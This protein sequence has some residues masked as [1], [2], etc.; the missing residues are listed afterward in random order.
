MFK[1]CFDFPW[2]IYAILYLADFTDINNKQQN[3]ATSYSVFIATTM[4]Q[5]NLNE[6]QICLWLE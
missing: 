3:I 4:V 2:C 6:K 5:T 1:F